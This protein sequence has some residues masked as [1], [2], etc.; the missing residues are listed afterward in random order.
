LL[1]PLVLLLLLALLVLEAFEFRFPQGS[2]STRFNRIKFFVSEL[3]LLVS[4]LRLFGFL[5]RFTRQLRVLS[6]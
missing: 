2:W 1:K 5:L 6:L 3:E 4:L